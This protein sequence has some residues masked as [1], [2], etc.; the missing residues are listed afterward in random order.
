VL[1]LRCSEWLEAEGLAKEVWDNL[2]QTDIRFTSSVSRTNNPSASKAALCWGISRARGLAGVHK[3]LR[4]S[5]DGRDV[6]NE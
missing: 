2:R 4:F 1:W 3:I 5:R 6:P